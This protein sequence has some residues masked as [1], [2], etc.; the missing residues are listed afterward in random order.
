MPLD[1]STRFL[2]IESTYILFLH[3]TVLNRRIVVNRPNMATAAREIAVSL[4]KELMPEAHS[5]EKM[6]V[7]VHT[8]FSWQIPRAN[9]RSS[10]DKTTATLG[11]VAFEYESQKHTL[12][13]SR[14]WKSVYACSL[15]TITR[16]SL[17]FAKFLFSTLTIR[18]KLSSE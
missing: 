18:R 10:K 16:P 8:G 3:R 15:Q 1:I 7:S 6:S 2:S 17:D 5:A 11:E 4:S 9:L 12:P 13:I 14:H